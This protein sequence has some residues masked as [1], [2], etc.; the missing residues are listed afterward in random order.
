MTP[1]SWDLELARKGGLDGRFLVGLMTAGIYSLPSCRVKPANSEKI[2]TFS[3]VTAAKAAGLRACTIC[4]PDRLYRADDENITSFQELVLRLRTHPEN[5]ADAADMARAAG[6]TKGKL[7][8]L[9]RDHAHLSPERWLLRMR[10][11]A[12]GIRL[13]QDRRAAAELAVETGFG[14][15]RTFE[16]E[17]LREMR[18]TAQDYRALNAKRGFQLV[19]PRGYRANEILA[20]QGRDSQ[21]PCER[22]DGNRIWKALVTRDGPVILELTLEPSRAIVR[23]HSKG[24]VGR[25][26]VA[27]LHRDALGILGLLGEVQ[28]FESEHADFVRGRR[29]VR[30]SL[31]RGF[32]AL[33]W[34]ITGQQIN[35]SFASTLRRELIALAGQKIDGMLAHPTPEAVANLGTKAL[36]AVRYSRSKAKYLVTVAATIAGGHLNVDGLAEGSAVAAERTLIAQ[37]GIGLWTARYVMLRTGFADSAPVGDSGLATALERLHKLPERPDAS[38]TARLMSPFSPYRS[39]A[40]AHLWTRLHEAP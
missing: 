35:L 11:R 39:L 22:V 30:L 18:M 40:S 24:A 28:S 12:V 2:Q 1:L 6:M 33:C 7:E 3:T 21:S 15:P 13:L 26:S 10:V 9:F 14:D 29:G 25:D 17:F 27:V 23:I 5:I 37:H 36:T 34:A 8:D 31:I 4:R 38:Q 19:L 32:D 16:R 20:Y